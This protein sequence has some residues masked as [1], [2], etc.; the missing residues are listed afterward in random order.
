[1]SYNRRFS[2]TI[3]IHYSG[4]VSYPA[5]ERGGTVSYSGYAT[6]VVDVNVHVDTDPFDNSIDKCNGQVNLL[7][8]AVVAT[9]AAQVKSINDNSRQVASTIVKGFFQ[10]IG[11]EISQQINELKNNIE[12]TSL[13]LVELARRCLEKKEQMGVDYQRLCQRYMKIFENLNNELENRIYEVDRPIFGMKEKVSHYASL[14]EETDMVSTVVVS[15]AEEAKLQAQMASASLKDKASV[16]INAAYGYLQK[17]KV[18]NQSIDTN[19]HNE[20]I[21][22]TYYVPVIASSVCD[23]AGVFTNKLYSADKFDRE[24]TSNSILQS[25]MRSEWKPMSQ[26]EKDKIEQHFNTEV[27]NHFTGT[28]THEARVRS[29]VL[30]MFSDNS[31]QRL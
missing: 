20:N 1:M 24:L 9:E 25:L 30:K 27:S 22:A 6:E 23:E 11:S 18:M 28:S 31:M 7:T 10:T 17:Q 14:A 3:T 2:K 26:A 4:T 21:S 12:A 5:S 19:M 16:A 13:H 15:G 8:G 29:A